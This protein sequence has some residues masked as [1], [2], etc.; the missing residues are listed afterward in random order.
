MA[1]KVQ[2]ELMAAAFPVTNAS[3]DERGDYQAV[4]YEKA[5]EIVT[6]L[7]RELATCRGDEFAG[8]P[9]KWGHATRI[10]RLEQRLERI[11]GIGYFTTALNA[12]TWEEVLPKI[13]ELQQRCE[14]LE[15][16]NAALVADLEQGF[17]PG[18]Y[19]RLKNLQEAERR[20]AELER[21]LQQSKDAFRRLQLATNCACHAIRTDV[22]Y[23]EGSV[24][25]DCFGNVTTALATREAQLA[26]AR[27]TIRQML[28]TFESGRIVLLGDEQCY[29]THADL[30]RVQRW[31]AA[32]AALSRE[33]ESAMDPA[34]RARLEAKGW[35]V[36]DA[37]EFLDEVSGEGKGLYREYNHT[38][39]DIKDCPTC[40]PTEQ[41]KGE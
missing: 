35:A 14:R 36:G 7:E 2:E 24:C 4:P 15:Q 17:M 30:S 6:R 20:V 11:P 5:R 25:Q 27:E 1:S 28:C 41:P 12:G 34:K 23:I 10:E 9:T 37:E 29:Q 40:T 18:S 26:T 19:A 39:T 13:N 8:D 32:L 16:Q 22:S 31:N 33:G 21:E 3:S 38:M